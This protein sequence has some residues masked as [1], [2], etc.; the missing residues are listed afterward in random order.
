MLVTLVAFLFIGFLHIPFSSGIY[1]I[2]IKSIEILD[3]TNCDRFRETAINSN[4]TVTPTQTITGPKTG[5][6]GG[7]G[8]A[9]TV[10]ISF[11]NDVA[12]DENAVVSISDMKPDRTSNK[13]SKTPPN[14]IRN[15]LYISRH[16]LCDIL[17][18]YLATVL[19][20]NAQTKPRKKVKNTPDYNEDSN[21]NNV[22]SSVEQSEIGQREKT[23]M[24]L[25]P[26]A[27]GHYV[28]P[29]MKWKSPPLSVPAIFLG[30]QKYMIEVIK[31]IVGSKDDV[32]GEMLMCNVVTVFLNPKKNY[33]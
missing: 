1:F 32:L 3:V 29:K 28:L 25:C 4:V 6:D 7:G 23:K 11:T 15:K 12:L 18:N 10:S 26:I 31:P 21:S 19:F 17:N 5:K 24:K 33:Y 20:G 30:Y 2:P 22:E 14:W 16:N 8:K 9:Q 27:A 13:N